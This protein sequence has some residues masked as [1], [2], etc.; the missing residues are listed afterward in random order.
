MTLVELNNFISEV[1]FRLYPNT[2]K[3]VINSK[4]DKFLTHGR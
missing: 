3:P 4:I 2:D 1:Y